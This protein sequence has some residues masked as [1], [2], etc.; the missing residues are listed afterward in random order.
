MADTLLYQTTDADLADDAVE[1]LRRSGISCYRTGT[2]LPNVKGSIGE[3]ISIFVR[4]PGDYGRASD[5]ILKLGALPDEP[6]R[7]YYFWGTWVAIAVIIA[8]I[9]VVSRSGRLF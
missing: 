1:A 4:T 5:L 3:T 8:V 2:V 6:T 9:I 7:G